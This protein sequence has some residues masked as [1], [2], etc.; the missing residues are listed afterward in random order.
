M[1]IKPREIVI[2]KYKENINQNSYEKGVNAVTINPMAQAAKE[3]TKF[4]K[5]TLAAESTLIKNLSK[6]SLGEWQT[7]TAKSFDKLQEKVNKAVDSGKWNA[8]KVLEAGKAAHEAVKN[9]P[10][11]TLNQSYDRYIA[12][13]NTIINKY[14]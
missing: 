9:M 13:Q 1:T 5:N 3:K 7:A 6:V 14:K 4:E 12:A 8:A 11:G 2:K 10:K